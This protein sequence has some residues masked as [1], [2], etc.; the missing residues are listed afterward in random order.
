L[1][2]SHRAIVLPQATTS[3]R[4]QH[5]SG[6]VPDYDAYVPKKMLIF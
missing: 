1:V 5:R 6:W 3:A 4:Q 2:E